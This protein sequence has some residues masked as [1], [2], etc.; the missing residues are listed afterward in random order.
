[1]RHVG[2]SAVGVLCAVL[3]APPGAYADSTPP[4]HPAQGSLQVAF[5]PW[6]DVDTLLID[7]IAAARDRVLVQ[8][9][10]LTSKKMANA[11]IHAHRR[12][13]DVQVLLDER[14]LKNVPSSVAPL[15][16]KAGIPVWIETVY[17]NAHNKVI[18]IDPAAPTA[19]VVTGS[20][21]FTW[22]A[23]HRNAE[24]MLIARE[25]PSLAARYA[26]NWERHRRDASRYK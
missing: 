1:M 9:Y 26:E 18:V 7:A 22:T 25:N 16:T 24:N 19:T 17:Q 3:F 23:Q 5:T 8:A 10:L 14:Q 15:L 13:V 12:G 2:R 11:L 20:F 4:M 21:N 6:D